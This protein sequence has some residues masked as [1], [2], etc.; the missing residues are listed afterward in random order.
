MT[1]L[2]SVNLT[3]FRITRSN[4]IVIVY[5][6]MFGLRSPALCLRVGWF[7]H[8][9]RLALL[10]HSSKVCRSRFNCLYMLTTAVKRCWTSCLN[11]MSVSE[12]VRLCVRQCWTSCYLC[13][14]A[15]S[16]ETYSRQRPTL[17][18]PANLQP[19]SHIQD[20]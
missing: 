3:K 12:W 2:Y 14:L 10:S 11:K 5:V 15:S 8:I 6:K 19:L 1:G 9:H 20:N 18:L 16:Q 17:Q 4:S 7:M 13:Y